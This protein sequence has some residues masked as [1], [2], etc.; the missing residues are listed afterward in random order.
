M[1]TRRNT[2]NK[3]P[4]QNQQEPRKNCPVA[5]GFD[6][7]ENAILAQGVTRD[8]HPPETPKFGHAFR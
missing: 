4:C 5:A 2:V 6:R 1:I 8:N 3:M 7:C